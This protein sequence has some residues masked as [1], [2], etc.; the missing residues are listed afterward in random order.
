VLK[1]PPVL[2]WLDLQTQPTPRAGRRRQVSARFQLT[3]FGL[4]VKALV[5]DL[6]T[7]II[8]LIFG[9]PDFGTWSF[10]INSSYFFYGDFINSLIT[11]V[12]VAA[13]AFFFVIKPMNL[14]A[15]RR[16]GAVVERELSYTP[17]T[18]LARR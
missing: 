17:G 2:T 3:A 11:F 10:T 8:A 9:Q 12:S 13:A 18:R 7:P 16:A 1:C 4:V 14:L 15:V 5:A 6:L